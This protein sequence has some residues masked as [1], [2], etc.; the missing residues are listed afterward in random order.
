MD[1]KKAYSVILFAILLSSLL[2]VSVTASDS[3]E[4]F[5]KAKTDLQALYASLNRTKLQIVDSLNNSLNVNYSIEYT[6]DEGKFGSYD[7]SYDQDKINSSLDISEE[8]EG[9]LLDAHDL[10]KEIKGKVSSY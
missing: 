6:P 5:S 2:A 10:L 8:V 3:H 4:D 9:N 1:I 7:Y